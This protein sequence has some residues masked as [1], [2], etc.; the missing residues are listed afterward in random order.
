MPCVKVPPC[1]FLTVPKPQWQQTYAVKGGVEAEAA[2]KAYAQ[3]K[4]VDGAGA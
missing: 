4:A 2:F 1:E 3:G